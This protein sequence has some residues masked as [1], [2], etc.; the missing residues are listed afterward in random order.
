[1]LSL[2]FISIWLPKTV[3]ANDDR[4]CLFASPLVLGASVSKGY[5][6]PKGGPSSIVSRMLNPDAQILNLAVSGA[7]SV[8]STKNHQVPKPPPS[9]VLAFDLFFWDTAK[10]ACGEE[11]AANTARLIN[12]YKELGIPVVLGKIPVGVRFPMGVKA[13]GS[14]PCTPVINNLLAELCKEENNCFIYDPKD[15]LDAMLEPIS[16]EGVPYFYDALHT[17]DEGNLF[18]AHHFINSKKY[19][20]YR[21]AE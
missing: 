10:N 8:Q 15:C 16:P 12:M 13:A 17:S 18:C 19:Q 2:L 3:Y 21:C 20:E 14:R 7:S 9:I 1:M 4:K 11:F 6:A 5:G